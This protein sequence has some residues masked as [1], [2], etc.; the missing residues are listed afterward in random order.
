VD[1]FGITRN[2]DGFRGRNAAAAP[3]GARGGPARAK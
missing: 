2:M 1:F 3:P